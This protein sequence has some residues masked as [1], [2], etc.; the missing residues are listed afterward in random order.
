M[1]VPKRYFAEFSQSVPPT[2]QSSGSSVYTASNF[3][4]DETYWIPITGTVNPFIFSPATGVFL[5]TKVGFV[6]PYTTAQGLTASVSLRKTSDATNLG[7]FT[8][9]L[10]PGLSYH[11]AALAANAREVVVFGNA[12]Y[13]FSSS[14][15][16]GTQALMGFVTFK[17]PA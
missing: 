4:R 17:R 11:T 15:I 12:V 8:G 14:L 7:Q 3:S 16:T 13:H 2:I 5:V 1:G 6:N 10:N 9:V